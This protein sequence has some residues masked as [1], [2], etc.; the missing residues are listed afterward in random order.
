MYDR[1]PRNLTQ[2]GESTTE[3]VGPGTYDAD[4]PNVAKVRA[5]LHSTEI[6]IICYCLTV[7]LQVQVF[8]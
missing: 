1:A 5:G 6:P 2:A 3:H 7:S 8:L 4:L